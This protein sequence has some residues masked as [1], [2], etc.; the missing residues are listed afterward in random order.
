[1]VEGREHN[2]EAVNWALGVVTY[3]F[4]VGSPFDE[5]VTC[6]TQVCCSIISQCFVIDLNFVWYFVRN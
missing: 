4:V 2:N 1:M 5:I 3:E 6:L